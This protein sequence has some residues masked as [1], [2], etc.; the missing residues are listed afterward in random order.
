MFIEIILNIISLKAL[1]NWL[2]FIGLKYS[3]FK[4]MRVFKALRSSMIFDAHMSLLRQRWWHVHLF[5]PSVQHPIT[6]SNGL[7][8][9]WVCLGQVLLHCLLAIKHG[10]KIL[11]KYGWFPSHHRRSPRSPCHSPTRRSAEPG[12]CAWRFGGWFICA[13]VPHKRLIY[14]LHNWDFQWA[15][16][17]SYNHTN[18]ISSIN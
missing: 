1:P 2:E 14:H 16:V 4:I 3:I 7:L 8:V 12:R 18:I 10:Q 9:L 5:K 6:S 13:R 11:L 17:I 15:K